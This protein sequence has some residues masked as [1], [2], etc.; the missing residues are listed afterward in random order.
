M[1]VFNNLTCLNFLTEVPAFNPNRDISCFLVVE[2]TDDKDFITNLAHSLLAAGCTTFDFYGKMEALWHEGVDHEDARMFHCEKVALTAGHDSMKEFTNELVRMVHDEWPAPRDFY[3]L[4]DDEKIF[5]D[6]MRGFEKCESQ[7]LRFDET[8]E[9]NMDTGY[10]IEAIVAE[11]ND[12]NS[13][14]SEEDEFD[15][16]HFYELYEPTVEIVRECCSK[17]VHSRAELRLVH[18]LTR[19]VYKEIYDDEQEECQESVWTLI[20][21]MCGWN[22][23]YLGLP[24]EKED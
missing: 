2:H 13:K 21:A 8:Q 22:L 15:A 17:D 3:L 6:V 1:R 10:D 19:F 11:W 14:I 16:G 9:D 12:L 18:E 23:G 20:D 5:E 7:K 24:A 4:Y